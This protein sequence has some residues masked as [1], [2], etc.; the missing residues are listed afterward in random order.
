MSRCASV[1]LSRSTPRSIHADRRKNY[2]SLLRCGSEVWRI[3][4]KSHTHIRECT[5]CK[6]Q[7]RPGIMDSSRG[8]R[9][10]RS[11]DTVTCLHN[12][13]RYYAMRS[14]LWTDLSALPCDPA[15]RHPDYII[16][17][18]V[19][20]AGRELYLEDLPSLAEMTR[21]VGPSG[22]TPVLVLVAHLEISNLHLCVHRGSVEGT[23][24]SLCM[25]VCTSWKV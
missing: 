24:L 4:Y 21:L 20:G 11:S 17:L 1:H 19:I 15:P 6:G 7:Y 16:I 25:L 13:Q 2:I 8:V 5:A 3:S 18:F 22:Q 14:I 9:E 23:S 10:T 12:A